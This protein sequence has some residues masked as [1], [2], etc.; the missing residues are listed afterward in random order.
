MI[1]RINVLIIGAGPAGMTAAVYASRANLTAMIVESG[2]PGG[3]LLKT[4]DI[5]NWPG[6]AKIAG[7]DLAYQMFEHSTT[8]GATFQYGDV[9]RIEDKGDYKVTHMADG[10]RIES[11]TVIIATGTK[12]ILLGI[13]GEE[14]YTA[15]GVSYCAVCDGGFFKN[16]VVT[17]VGG[18]NSA[19]E[20]ALYLTQFASK[21][22]LLVRRNVFR[23]EEYIQN[24]VR[25]HPKIE[26]MYETK[27]VK[28][29]GNGSNVTEMIVMDSKT[30]E[31]RTI[32]TDGVFPFIGSTPVTGFA[33]DLGILD[34][35]GY[36]VVNEFMETK[37]PGIYGAGDVCAKGL[38]QI[39]TA[40]SDG[41]IAAQRIYHFLH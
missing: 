1:E 32:K 35:S 4:S 22:Q 28:I 40:V 3:K 29:I 31:Q 6:A 14:E 20:E 26:V 34:E 13:P 19:L 37:V 21:V 25:N 8:Y 11:D 30:D 7:P 41:A 12:E 9:V 27:P 33:K 16:C 38:R 10:N 24:K 2:A 36:V 15:K 5:E 39:V 23:A 17:V 18:G